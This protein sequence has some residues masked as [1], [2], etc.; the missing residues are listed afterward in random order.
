MNTGVYDISRYGIT[1]LG[2]AAV[3]FVCACAFAGYKRGFVKEIVSLLFLFLSF[4]LVWYINPYVNEFLKEN[5]KIQ[6]KVEAHCEDLLETAMHSEKFMN[7]RRQEIVLDELPIPTILKEKMK[8][9]NH[10]EIYDY[11]SVGSFTEYVPNYLAV[12]IMN[13]LSFMISYFLA[14]ILIKTLAY[15]LDIMARLPLIRGVNRIFGGVIGIVK[16][17]FAIWLMLLVLTLLCNTELGGTILNMVN[18]DRILSF[19]YEKNIFVKVF[20]NVFYG[21]SYGS[22]FI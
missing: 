16:G 17:I 6:Q 10:S 5:T 19:L 20:M 3:V 7:N 11:L 13:G 2:I 12:M 18:E 21:S 8:K 9:D 4:G 1:G 15:A 22:S 14:S